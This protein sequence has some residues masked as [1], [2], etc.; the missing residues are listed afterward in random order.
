MAKKGP[1]IQV[2]INNSNE[3]SGSGNSSAN[4]S[5]DARASARQSQTQSQRQTGRG[6]SDTFSSEQ[7]FEKVGNRWTRQSGGQ[8]VFVDWQE[9]AALDEMWS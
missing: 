6:G 9:S 4:A 3:I 1:D 5:A 2:N 8:R 7:Q